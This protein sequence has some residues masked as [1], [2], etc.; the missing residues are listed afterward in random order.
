MYKKILV[1]TDGSKQSEKAGEYAVSLV[2][3][4]LFYT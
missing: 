1:P 3:R 4:S 2:Q